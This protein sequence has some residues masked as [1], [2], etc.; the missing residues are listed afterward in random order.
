MCPVF[1]AMVMEMTVMMRMMATTVMMMMTMM[2]VVNAH[3]CCNKKADDRDVWYIHVKPFP[4]HMHHVH[5]IS[6]TEILRPN[7]CINSNTTAHE[8]DEMFLLTC[9]AFVQMLC[10]SSDKF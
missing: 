10:A 2:M 8:I 1:S 3:N 7:F 4:P 6:N 9:N 5:V